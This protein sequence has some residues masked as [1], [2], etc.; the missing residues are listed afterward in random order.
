MNVKIYDPSKKDDIKMTEQ[1]IK[2]VRNEMKKH[3]NANGFRLGVKAAGCSG[4]KYVV[5]LIETPEKDDLAFKV[6]DD[7]TVYVDPTS[8]TYVKGTTIDFVQQ[9]LNK[10]F[11]YQNPYEAGACGCGESFTVKDDDENGENV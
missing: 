11:V 5:D 7:I 1:A 10:I 9:G 2:H 4:Q 6:S 3:A 8:F